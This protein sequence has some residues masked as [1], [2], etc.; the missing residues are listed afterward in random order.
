LNQS[1]RNDFDKITWGRGSMKHWA[2][3][4]Q[5]YSSAEFRAADPSFPPMVRCQRDSKKIILKHFSEKLWSSKDC[6]KGQ[7][8]FGIKNQRSSTMTMILN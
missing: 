6:F 3:V 2:P 4:C 7:D 5:L 8:E 1:L